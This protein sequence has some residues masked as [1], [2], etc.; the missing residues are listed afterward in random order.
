[1][2]TNG[3]VNCLWLKDTHHDGIFTGY[4]FGKNKRTTFPKNQTWERTMKLGILGTNLY[5][6]SRR[7][8]KP[9]FAF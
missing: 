4:A 6:V 9:Y 8:W 3:S 1:M 2:A 5:F 7:N